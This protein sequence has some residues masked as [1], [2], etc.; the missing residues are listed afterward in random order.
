M[1]EPISKY[2]SAFKNLCKRL[3]EV[4]KEN[5]VPKIILL[6]HALL[7]NILYGATPNNYLNFEFYK[8]R[9][10]ERKKYITRRKTLWIEKKLN[11]PKNAVYFNDKVKFNETFSEYVRRDWIFMLQSSK[12]Q[13]IK[14]INKHNKVIIKPTQLS[15]GRGIMVLSKTDNN[16]ENIYNEIKSKPFLVEE[17]V[18]QHHD[19]SLFNDSSINTVRVYTIIEKNGEPTILFAAVRIGSKGSCVDNYHSGGV[20]AGID[21]ETGTIY[22]ML[23]D[24]NN[25]R[26]IRHPST[27]IDVIG[28]KIPKWNDLKNIVRE[29]AK[30]FPTSRY[31]GWDIAITED[32]FEFIEGNYNSDPCLLQVIDKCGKYYLIKN[33]I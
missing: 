27:G 8:L 22:T 23:V 10:C 9:H 7:C 11:D 5:N 20:A 2:K 18:K 1:R 32:G 19:M 17:F 4:K 3:N 15:S 25:K 30:K 16:I 21:I 6:L 13:F 28:K 24:L 14:F 33:K 31:I 26:Y 12:E 29:A